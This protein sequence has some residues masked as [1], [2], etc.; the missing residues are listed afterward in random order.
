MNKGNSALSAKRCSIGIALLLL[1]GTSNVVAE[2][3]AIGADEYRL[4]C[5]A[6]HGVG[7]KGNGAL[8]AYMTPKPADLT[9]ISARNGGQYP[10]LKAGTFP[11]FHVYQV[12]DGRALVAGHGD[13][14]MPV[15]GDRYLM[16]LPQTP[17]AF[18]GE[19]EK[20]VRGR[21]LELVYYV[22]SIQQ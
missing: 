15:W 10:D 8:A 18:R 21:I 7:G 11:F 16:D 6:C 1:V 5:M 3:E 22:M 4:S 9:T 12:I 13:R 20:A 2:D 17:E 14:D 19:Y